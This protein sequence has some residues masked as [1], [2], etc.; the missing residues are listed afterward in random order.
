MGQIRV[1]VNEGDIKKAETNNSMRCVVA[2]AIARTIPDATRIDVDVQSIRWSREGERFVYLTPYSVQGYVVAFDAGEEIQPFTFVL[3]S[4]RRV[5]VQTMKT[6][7][8]GKA[9]KRARDKETK[10]RTKVEQ[11]ELTAKKAKLP[12]P[13]P[14]EVKVAKTQL[15]EAKQEAEA[16][17]TE[18]EKVKAA[19]Q[20][21]VTNRREGEGRQAGPPRVQ[22][23]SERHYGMRTLRINRPA[24]G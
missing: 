1:Q 19:Y 12:P 18:L 8:A 9:I 3:D 22:K 10:K 21:A 6:T 7:E 14:T 24:N 2:Q 11:L 17:A 15:P 4:R 5:P 16:A 20:G 23:S 13:T